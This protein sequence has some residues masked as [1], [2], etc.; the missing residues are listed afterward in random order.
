MI[1]QGDQ[2]LCFD[3]A[4]LTK[5]Y[6]IF[7]SYAMFHSVKGNRIFCTHNSD[8]TKPGFEVSFIV[9]KEIHDKSKSFR[10]EYEHLYKAK[11]DEL[12]KVLD[13]YYGVNN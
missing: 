6:S 8:F 11:N 7:D 3:T 2:V 12:V 13:L 9:P 10:D 5:G 1:K 4:D